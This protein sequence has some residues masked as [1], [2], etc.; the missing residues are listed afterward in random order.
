MEGFCFHT[1]SYLTVVKPGHHFVSGMCSAIFVHCSKSCRLHVPQR[2]GLHVLLRNADTQRL[3]LQGGMQII[4]DWSASLYEAHLVPAAHL[5]VSMGS[6]GVP[7]GPCLKPEVLASMAEPP[8]RAVASATGTHEPSP[9]A[10]RPSATG[11]D[12]R[13][14][15]VSA[16]EA[17]AAGGKKPK[18]MKIG[19]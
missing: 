15:E 3:M 9:G 14:A 7:S 4:K 8:P 13:P 11:L 6:S 1:I 10:A 16:R 5:H 19:K 12:A 18:W 2:G 17:G